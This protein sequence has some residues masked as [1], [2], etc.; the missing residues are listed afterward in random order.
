MA[1]DMGSDTIRK[2][3]FYARAKSANHAACVTRNDGMNT[4]LKN[5][6]IGKA[7][8]RLK[9]EQHLIKAQKSFHQHIHYCQSSVTVGDT[10]IREIKE[11]QSSV[12]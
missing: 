1:S 3:S 12:T 5:R 8:V 10:Q 2:D 4:P 11:G 7:M 6:P 9:K